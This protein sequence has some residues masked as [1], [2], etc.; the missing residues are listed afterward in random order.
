MSKRRAPGEFWLTKR[1]DSPVWYVATY[2]TVRRKTVLRST[3]TNDE[4][5]AQKCLARYIIHGCP[6]PQ[7]VLPSSQTA[8]GMTIG[9]A[10]DAYIAAVAGIPSEEQARISARHL[11]RLIGGRTPASALTYD[12]QQAFVWA[13][14]EEGVRPATISRDLSVL[15]AALNKAHRDHPNRMPTAPKIY[16]VPPSEGR[17]RYL[18]E[19]EFSRLL[20]AAKT[21]HMRLFIL[22]SV[23]TGARPDAILDLRWD[24]IDWDGGLIHLNPN[25][26][27]QTAKAR[28][29][30]PLIAELWDELKAEQEEE[31]RRSQTSRARARKRSVSEFV[32]SYG[33]Y[34][35]ESIRTSF[36]DAATRAG[37]GADVVPYT[38]RHTAATWL[39]QAG[40]P[41]WDIAQ[42][43]GHKDTRMVE[44]HYAHHNPEHKARAASVLAGKLSKA[45][46]NAPTLCAHRAPGERVAPQLHPR[47][48][49]G[50]KAM[51]ANPLA[52]MVGATG[53]E[54]VTPTMST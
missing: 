50:E 21:R 39:A 44:R 42:Y 32:I 40:T 13:R 20:A 10:L 12:D 41:L 31:A 47:R 37:L 33:G 34:A 6:E 22:L 17:K 46:E 16:D 45:R 54:P 52:A 7:G 30:V 23:A 28:P 29:I 24:A 9:E 3:R 4:V 5:A 14:E 25:G 18:T 11:V 2:D 26:R 49:A 15:R 8:D 1:P 19:E 35:V 43:L 27:I 51:M 38:L 36:R 53:I 48:G